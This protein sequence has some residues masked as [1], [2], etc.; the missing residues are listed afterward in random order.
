MVHSICQLSLL[1]SFELAVAQQHHNSTSLA[2][3]S[4]PQLHLLCF[5][6][7]LHLAWRAVSQLPCV[8]SR[9]CFAM[10]PSV[11]TN[12]SL[13]PAQTCDAQFSAY[14]H[15]CSVRR[16]LTHLLLLLASPETLHTHCSWPC[17][18]A[19]GHTQISLKMSSSL[20]D[21]SSLMMSA[22]PPMVALKHLTPL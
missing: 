19:S 9:I 12:C 16:R 4:Y 1:V 21:S 17:S 6:W 11:A 15:R 14:M 20:V 8:C 7:L 13:Q 10:Y 2:A 3:Y 18:S 5:Q 22:K